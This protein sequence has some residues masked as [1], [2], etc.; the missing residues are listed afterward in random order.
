MISGSEVAFFSLSP[1]DI[2]SLEEEETSTNQRIIALRETPRKL[3]ATILISNNLIN[4]AI[5]VFSYFIIDQLLPES[6][7]LSLSESI[8]SSIG[9][10]TDYVQSFS[11]TLYFII[12]VLGVT[13]ILLLFGEVAPKIYANTNN[14]SFSKKMALP[15]SVLNVLFGPLSKILV[16]WSNTL[17]ERLSR[18]RIG[19]S[20]TSKEDLDAAIDLTVLQTNTSD[21]EADILKSILKFGDVTVKQIMKSRVDVI[22]LE[23]KTSFKE[24]L[25]TIKEHGYSRIPVYQEDFDNIV[26]ILYVKDLLGYTNESADFDWNKL[27]RPNPLYT[28]EQKKIDDLL[29]EIQQK[30]VHLA[31]VVDEYGGSSGIV[32]LEDIMEEVIGD[33]KDEYDDKEE[34]E[35]IKLGEGNFVFE[36]KTLL[37]DVCRI[38]GIPLDDFIKVRGESDS[39]AGLILEIEGLMPKIDKEI[40][41]M[42]YKF[43]IIS[44][45]N[46]RIE[47]I[48]LQFDQ[49]AI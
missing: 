48:N 34:V 28:P 43:K 15:L 8:L 46:R 22:A 40:K 32:T 26:G 36:G 6:V 20:S 3:L 2:K 39:L 38:S 30:R 19:S 5:V 49:N 1:S 11:S 18:G 31:I 21:E 10:S 33:I 42:N 29:K 47:K 41:Y 25:S 13:S 37:N 17:E 35:Y 27:I 9:F 23:Q 14:L 24:L 45:S 7:L 16:R 4:I 44:V 12:T